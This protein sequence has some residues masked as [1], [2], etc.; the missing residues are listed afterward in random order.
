M[1][2][3][4]VFKSAANAKPPH[5]S[6]RDTTVC[7]FIL[8]QQIDAYKEKADNVMQCGQCND[9]DRPARPNVPVATGVHRE[10]PVFQQNRGIIMHIYSVTQPAR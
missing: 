6:H 5:R 4:Y 8:F 7:S 9:T 2:A 3:V 10:I 1:V